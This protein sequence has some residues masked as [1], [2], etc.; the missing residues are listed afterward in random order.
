MAAPQAGA[1]EPASSGV[2]LDCEATVDLGWGE[3]GPATRPACCRFR[4]RVHKLDPAAGVPPLLTI[5]SM[6]SLLALSGR[7]EPARRR[8]AAMTLALCGAPAWAAPSEAPSIGPWLF[9]STA[10][11]LVA[12]L[13]YLAG[14][15]AP[16]HRAPDRQ[17]AST[18]PAKAELPA[19]L[20]ALMHG[21]QGALRL[22][23][24][25]PADGGWTLIAAQPPLPSG[26]PLA[27]LPPA[28][29]D[30]AERLAPDSSTEVEGWRMRRSGQGPSERL[31]LRRADGSADSA[32]QQAAYSFTV[33]HDLRAPVRV[34]EGFAR[35]LK[36]DYGRQLD[37]IGNDHLDRVLGAAAR[38]NAMIDAMLSLARLSS[39]PLTRQ[40][41]NLSQLAGYVVEDL[42]RSAPERQV[43]FEIEPGLQADGDPTLLRQVVENLLSNAWKYS[44]RCTQARIAF[45]SAE[46]DGRRVFEVRDNGA[47]FDMRSAERLFGLFQRLHSANDFAGTGVGLASVQRIVR[48]HGGDIWAEAEPGRGAHFYF[49]LAG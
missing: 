36:E 5:V 42:R 26:S 8:A 4:P 34:V 29:R 18:L 2:E 23:Q 49:T 21:E 1:K 31:V 15:R 6:R 35:I 33:S 45:T 43:D 38:M 39:Q 17:V 20:A 13:A 9:G 19:S 22:C 11:V 7:V 28:A 3:L 25:S 27:D 48:R 12:L 47:G 37:R 16:A 44:A 46:R 32:E 10:L 24:R 30:A 14:R 40:P 41:V